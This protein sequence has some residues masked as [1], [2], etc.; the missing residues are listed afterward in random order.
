MGDVKLHGHIRMNASW[1]GLVAGY[2]LF[3]YFGD[4]TM[5]IWTAKPKTLNAK[6]AN[7]I[8]PSATDFSINSMNIS[9]GMATLFSKKT[10]K[11]FGRAKVAGAEVTIPVTGTLALGDTL[12]L[13][14][15]SHNY[16][17]V[18]RN[19]PVS[20]DQTGIG[21]LVNMT[22][23]AFSLFF[24]NRRYTLFSG[25]DVSI[26]V[27][28]VNGQ[29]VLGHQWKKISGDIKLNSVNLSS[30]RYFVRI[31]QGKREIVGNTLIMR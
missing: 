3:H 22:K 29:K 12:I 14:I 15:R 30:G 2:W 9:E 13:T 11:L 1:G 27:F 31:K 19:I 20:N 7:L 26:S 6:H 5:E 24:N 18:I 28:A 17:P 16:L 21:D 25:N 10:D 23:G 4:P 8:H